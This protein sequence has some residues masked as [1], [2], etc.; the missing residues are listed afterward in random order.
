MSSARSA[1]QRADEKAL[2]KA[3]GLPARGDAE[4]G[5]FKTP[6]PPKGG[7]NSGGRGRGRNKQG[8]LRRGPR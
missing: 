4:A 1:R 8:R 2:R 6:Y 5:R 3:L 7:R